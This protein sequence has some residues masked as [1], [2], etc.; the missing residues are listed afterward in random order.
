MSEE[1]IDTCVEDNE[2]SYLGAMHVGQDVV[3]EFPKRF[4]V[5]ECIDACKI[6][7]AKNI[8]TFMCSDE[9]SEGSW[10]EIVIENLSIENQEKIDEIKPLAN[11]IFNYHKGAINF[12]VKGKDDKASRKLVAIADMFEFQ[13]VQNVSAY[14]TEEQFLIHMGCYVEEKNPNYIKNP[15]ETFEYT[16]EE[17]ELYRNSDD[18]TKDIEVFR[19]FDKDK[20]LKSIE[21]YV[22]ES[23]YKGLYI[24]AEKRIYTSSFYLEKHKNYLSKFGKTEVIKKYKL[25]SDN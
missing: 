25:S 21:E 16:M 11:K 9:L 20:V 3:E 1:K 24:P 13:D 10:I 18:P 17:L 8:D 5:T 14:F 15:F 2:D 7:W 4:I 6:L 23:E 12:Q 19:V 22:K